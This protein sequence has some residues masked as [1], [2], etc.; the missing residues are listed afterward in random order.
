MTPAKRA[1]LTP[2]QWEMLDRI[3]RTNGGGIH[4]GFSEGARGTKTIRVLEKHGLVQ[5]KSGN[6]GC[7]VHTRK[8]LAFWRTRKEM[9]Q[10]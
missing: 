4:A 2:K 5:G 8:G 3:C 7:A 6:K 9:E 10:P 1:E